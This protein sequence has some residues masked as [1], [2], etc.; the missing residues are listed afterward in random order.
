MT[1]ERQPDQSITP[2]LPYRTP[3]LSRFG[4]V[5]ELTQN[6]LMVGRMDGGANNSRTG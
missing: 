3:S 5:L 4:A 1:P 6:R 2:R